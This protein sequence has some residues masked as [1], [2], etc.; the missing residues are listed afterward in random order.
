MTIF[1]AELAGESLRLA[2]EL[3]AAGLR[4]VTALQGDKIGKQFREADTKGIPCVVVI[5]PDDLEAGMVVVRDLKAGEQ[6][7]VARDAVLPAI[8]TLLH[9]DA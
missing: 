2:N 6:Q 9:L 3:R 1:N 5:G 8:R 7:S 4:V